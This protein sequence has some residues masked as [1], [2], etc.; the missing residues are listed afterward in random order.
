M[1]KTYGGFPPVKIKKKKTKKEKKKKNK[2]VRLIAAKIKNSVSINQI[3]KS[4]KSNNEIKKNNDEELSIVD[5][6]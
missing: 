5:E 1:D 4:K 2:N 3:L 6:L